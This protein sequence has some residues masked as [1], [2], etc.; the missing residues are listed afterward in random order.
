MEKLNDNSIMP[1]GA[2]K[3]KTLENVPANYLIW[4]YDNNKLSPALRE[5]V[6]ENRDVL[7]K[8]AKE[9]T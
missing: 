6:E 5:Y 4:C 7:E 8:Q 3:G 9:S 2:H 1:T